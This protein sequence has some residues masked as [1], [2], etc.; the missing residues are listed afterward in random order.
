MGLQE[1]QVGALDAKLGI[2]SPRAAQWKQFLQAWQACDARARKLPRGKR[3]TFWRTA[4][5][6]QAVCSVFAPATG[7]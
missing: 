4:A 6:R 2:D 5:F 7:R 1:A 3:E